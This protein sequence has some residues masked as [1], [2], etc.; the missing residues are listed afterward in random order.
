MRKFIIAALMLFAISQMYEAKARELKINKPERE[1]SK[2]TYKFGGYVELKAYTDDY[3]SKATRNQMIYLYP[4]APEYNMGKDINK[5]STLNASVF[6]SRLNF[7]VSGMEFM[8]AKVNTFIEADFNGSSQATIYMLNIRHAY[9]NMAWG[10]SSL[11]M[12]QTDHLTLVNEVTASTLAFIAG[13]PFNP[14]NRS[15]QLRYTYNLAQNIKFLAA[16]HLYSAH[17]SVGPEDAQANAKIPDLQFQIKLGDP[18]KTFGGITAGYKFLKPIVYDYQHN[19]N[20]PTMGTFNIGAFLRTNVEDKILFK[21]WASYGKNMTM[22]GQ[23]GGYL[24]EWNEHSSVKYESIGAI[25]WWQDT[26]V[27]LKGNFKAGFFAGYQM[28][29]NASGKIRSGINP[30]TLRD[31]KLLWFGKI[32]PRLTYNVSN[33]FILGV[34]YSRTTARWAQEINGKLEPLSKHPKTANNRIELMAKVIF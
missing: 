25:S 12:G 28:R 17:K 27:S 20:A 22:L 30:E 21:T 13:Y 4:L 16:A 24:M 23:L 26:E 15:I 7:S 10:N 29:L 14:L 34:E 32:S 31:Q 1:E 18:Q 8:N 19:T 11:L 5:Y 2:I 3:K 6:A 33:R 9:I